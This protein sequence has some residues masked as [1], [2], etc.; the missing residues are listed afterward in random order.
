MTDTSQGPGWWQASDGKWYPPE[1]HPN[2]RPPPPPPPKPPRPTRQVQ[3]VQPPPAKKKTST[4]TQVKLGCAGLVVVLIL[5]VVIAGLVGG[6]NTPPKSRP[7]GTPKTGSS[8]SA[9]STTQPATS[10][11]TTTAPSATTTTLSMVAQVKAWYLTVQSG[12]Q[13]VTN[14]FTALQSSKGTLT[15]IGRA[16]SQIAS[17]A[18][19]LQADPPAPASAIN[20]PYQSAL[21]DWSEGGNECSSGVATDDLTLINKATTDFTAGNSQILQATGEVKALGGEG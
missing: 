17:A 13:A 7:T 21:Y 14:A 10:S 20:T 19:A 2:Y 1:S 4:D 3:P 8:R 9:D 5:V 12:F 16:C 6:S 11:T 18:S 15:A